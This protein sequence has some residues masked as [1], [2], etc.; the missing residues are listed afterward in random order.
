MKNMAVFPLHMMLLGAA[1]KRNTELPNFSV[2][3]WT[4]DPQRCG[5]FGHPPA[6][7]LQ[8]GRDVVVF[9]A[10]A[11][12]AEGAGRHERERRSIELQRRQN[13]FDLNHRVSVSY[14]HLR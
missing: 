2:Q 12:L 13:V 7:V 10:E 4:L 5:G 1:G 11:G 9:E 8:D 14:T 3:V 6:V